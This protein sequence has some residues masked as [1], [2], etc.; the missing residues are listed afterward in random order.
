MKGLKRFLRLLFL[1][2][3]LSVGGLALRKFY[4]PFNNWL[5][6]QVPE[7]NDWLTENTEQ[8]PVVGGEGEKGSPDDESD[9]EDG[10]GDDNL[11]DAGNRNPGNDSGTSPKAT[12]AESA[13]KAGIEVWK[14][15]GKEISNLEEA[16]SHFQD[17]VNFDPDY[18]D[19]WLAKGE[20]NLELSNTKN[21][22]EALSDFNQCIR[23]RP[24]SGE[25]FFYRGRAKDKLGDE[26]GACEDYIQAYGYGCMDAMPE[27]DACE[28]KANE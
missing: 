21:Y 17:A 23:I 8:I 3:V 9:E 20:V 6:A 18:F 1:L 26:D 12:K 4:P 7:F 10:K 22:Q 28:E 25:A 11:G 24:K 14:D 2:L 27:R 19:A 15:G 13:Y 5:Q 16:H